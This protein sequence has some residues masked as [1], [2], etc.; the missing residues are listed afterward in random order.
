VS[1]SRPSFFWYSLAFE[2]LPSREL[3]FNGIFLQQ[4]NK[5]CCDPSRISLRNS[6]NYGIFM[7][8]MTSSVFKIILVMNS[9]AYVSNKYPNIFFEMFHRYRGT[10]KRSTGGCQSFFYEEIVCSWRFGITR[11][12]VF[13]LWSA[14]SQHLKWERLQ[15]RTLGLGAHIWVRVLSFGGCHEILIHWRAVTTMASAELVSL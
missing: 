5:H 8:K 6:N 7:C 13:S 2:T 12:R 11:F 4:K 10:W 15:H 3:P 1:V 9:R 14:H